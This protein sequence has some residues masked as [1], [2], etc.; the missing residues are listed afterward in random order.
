MRQK[1]CMIILRSSIMSY[2]YNIPFQFSKPTFITDLVI[3]VM[4]LIT[5]FMFF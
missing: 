4:T 3:Y 1:N 5:K 2:N